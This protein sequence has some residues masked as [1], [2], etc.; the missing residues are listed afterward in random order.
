MKK[1]GFQKEILGCIRWLP[2]TSAKI[3]QTKKT[4]SE[5]P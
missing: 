4:N 3:K 5:E 1:A 2:G